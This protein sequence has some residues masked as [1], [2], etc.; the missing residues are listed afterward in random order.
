MVILLPTRIVTGLYVTAR[1]LQSESIRAFGAS[2]DQHLCI[3]NLVIKLG[4][5]VYI[6]GSLCWLLWR[7][8]GKGVTR[9]VCAFGTD[10][11]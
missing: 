4:L 2:G 5:D 9:Y 8:K 7:W 3:V 10:E 1:M 11:R 6:T